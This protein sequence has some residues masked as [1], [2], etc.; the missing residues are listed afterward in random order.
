MYIPFLHLCT[1][2][3]VQLGS[4]TIMF[5]VLLLKDIRANLMYNEFQKVH[6]FNNICFCC[7]LIN[8]SNRDS[9]RKQSN[10]PV[11]WD[12]GLVSY[13]DVLLVLV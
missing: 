10:H 5:R 7:H 2:K 1:Y 11:L 13:K 8:I 6:S 4:I 3:Y 12:N 9:R